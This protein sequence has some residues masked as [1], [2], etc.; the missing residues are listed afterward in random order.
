MYVLILLPGERY[1]PFPTEKV[2]C[3]SPQP[4]PPQ[5]SQGIGWGGDSI[6]RWLL[7]REREGLP[8]PA[9]KETGVG[10]RNLF[11]ITFEDFFL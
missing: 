10:G 3:I 8:S 9:L 5:P 6:C 2:L 11:E 7:L 1:F 4:F